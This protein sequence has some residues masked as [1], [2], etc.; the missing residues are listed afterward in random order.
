MS[1]VHPPARE[2]I[3][4]AIDSG[5]SAALRHGIDTGENPFVT[6]TAQRASAPYRVTVTW[7]TRETG[8]YR[9]FT[10]MVGQGVG[11]RDVSLTKAREALGEPPEDA[12]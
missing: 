7:H 9:L 3:L 12:S 10:S 5:W 4:Q 8:T 11:A 1:T 2:L 6:V